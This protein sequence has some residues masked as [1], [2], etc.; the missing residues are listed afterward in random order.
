MVAVEGGGRATRR[1]ER[2]PPG[3]YARAFDLR[4]V[5]QRKRTCFGC[6]R[7]GVQIPPPRPFT[8]MPG[9]P[10]W[11]RAPRRGPRGY[12]V[13]APLV[14][15]EAHPGAGQGGGQPGGLGRGRDRVVLAGQDQ[16]R[17]GD[18]VE[19][20]PGVEPGHGARAQPPL[21]V[22]V[23]LHAGEQVGPDAVGQTPGVERDAALDEGPRHLVARLGGVEPPGDL[24]H[25][26]PAGALEHGE[27]LLVGG[28]HGAV[29]HQAAE[30]SRVV[31]RALERHP[32]AG[33]RAKHDRSVDPERVPHSP[34]TSSPQ[35]SHSQSSGAPRSERPEPRRSR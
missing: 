34:A 26:G 21:D 24:G 2:A 31:E 10:G 22:G 13:A 7:S 23:A 27:G 6:R 11:R 14:A 20:V 25:V 29:Q 15:F 1:G 8:A 33:G 18:L 16:H 19:P 5:A 35:R 3:R 17:A 4:G 28:G 30:P 9:T 12:A 32:G